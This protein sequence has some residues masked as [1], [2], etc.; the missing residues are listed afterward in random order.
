MKKRRRFKPTLSLQERLAEH[1][2]QLREEA[3]TLPAG[4]KRANCC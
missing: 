3:E 2:E 4:P 1:A